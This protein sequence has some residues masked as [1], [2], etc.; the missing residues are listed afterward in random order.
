MENNIIQMYMYF[1]I[2]TFFSLCVSFNLA[3]S[4]HQKPKVSFAYIH[5]LTVIKHVL[6]WLWV[7]DT[8]LV[9]MQLMFN[10][11][12]SIVFRVYWMSYHFNTCSIFLARFVPGNVW[13]TDN[14]SFGT[15]WSWENYSSQHV[16]WSGAP[17]NWYCNCTRICKWCRALLILFCTLFVSSFYTFNFISVNKSITNLLNGHFLF[18]FLL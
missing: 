5:L 4:H 16:K 11:S 3:W 8:A 14:M 10:K 1:Y 2:S 12:K 18:L 6:H 17:F 7:S 9:R 15:Q 13:G